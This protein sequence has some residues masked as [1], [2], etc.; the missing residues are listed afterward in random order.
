VSVRVRDTWAEFS[1]QAG[2]GVGSLNIVDSAP[3]FAARLMSASR[4]GLAARAA[5]RLDE[6]SPEAARIFGEGSF[7][8]WRQEIERFLVSL[9]AAVAH[10]TV[11]AW[12]DELRWL[13]TSYGTRNVDPDH[14]VRALE[15]MEEV[16]E[17]DLPTPAWSVVREPFR[18]GLAV[19]RRVEPPTASH[20]DLE[21]NTGKLA[22]EYLVAALEGDRRRAI[23]GVLNAV[24][25]G[26][27][28]AQAYLD[29]LMLAQA[30]VGRMWHANELS[31]AEEHAVTA[32]TELA[33]SQLYPRI[34]LP[35]MARG[36]V[37]AGAIAGDL[38]D[39]GVRVT[40]DFLEME[41]FRCVFIG[42]DVPPEEFARAA[43]DFEAD[44]V[45]IGATRPANLDRVRQAVGLIHRI[46]G[47]HVPV[48]V[49]GRAFS[50]DPDAWTAT[51]ADGY[52][53][54]ART[55]A[56]EALRLVPAPA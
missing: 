47:R 42:A 12:L 4:A 7:E 43:V 54:D 24:D 23:E 48:V 41:G 46:E 32:T 29:V 34:P 56:R 21:T 40:A 19:A 49:G 33:L 3:A 22:A 8:V 11:Q 53:T 13:R 27:P 39:I 50:A 18:E 28:I 9:E 2:R 20:I 31:I 6:A 51:G 30:E 35:E 55:A 17:Q 15:A 16:L 5:R 14:L 26:L 1:L 36:T 44:L 10:G 52:A 38:H 25:A 45:V 37:V